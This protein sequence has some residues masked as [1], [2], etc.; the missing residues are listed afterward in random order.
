[1]F[2][3]KIVIPC[4]NEPNLQQTLES[5]L[6]CTR[7]QSN[8]EIFVIINH[9][10]DS[11]ID[12]ITEN[13]KTYQF[14]KEYKSNLYKI[15]T[16]IYILNKQSV[17]MARKIGMDM[18]YETLKKYNNLKNGIIINLDAD[19]TVSENY[20][21]AIENHFKKYP[22]TPAASIYFEHQIIDNQHIIDYELHLRYLV[23]ALRWTCH[24]YAYQTVGSSMATRAESYQ[25]QGGMNTKQAGED[26]YFLQ[27]LMDLGNFSD[28]LDTTIFP[29]ARI[30]TRVPFGTG[31]AMEDMK[32]N[33][34]WYSY[35]FNSYL[36]IKNFITQTQEIYQNNKTQ[37]LSIA[38]VEYLKISNFETKIIEIKSNTSN[39]IAF[40]KRF[41]HWFNGFMVMKFLNFA[42]EHYYEKQ[43]IEIAVL[44]L[45]KILFP[46]KNTVNAKEMLLCMRK[47]DKNCGQYVS[48]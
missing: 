25:K 41:F 38:M 28:I 35:H 8:V 2:D 9:T 14:S 30:S 15:N 29:S 16:N 42:R 34:N 13:E 48:L 11:K 33:E 18:A 39:Y 43:T 36:D 37:N 44:P 47:F 3:L 5:L 24:S 20:F 45:F 17:G 23:N 12:I 4:Y 6:A 19:C 32:K 21:L 40:K 1:M 26:F 22:K 31:R 7:P 10:S 46:T 27:K